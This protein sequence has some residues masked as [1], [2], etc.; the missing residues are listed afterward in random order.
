MVKD[1]H[2]ID[3]INANPIAAIVLDLILLRHQILYHLLQW[4]LRCF[5]RFRFLNDLLDCLVF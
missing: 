4:A 1:T 2:L 5:C 3:C